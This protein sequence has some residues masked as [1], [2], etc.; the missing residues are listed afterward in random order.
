MYQ[1]RTL[2][3]NGSSLG[4]LS[5]K[6]DSGTGFSDVNLDRLLDRIF[7]GRISDRK[8]EQSFKSGNR[9][10]DCFRQDR[11]DTVLLKNLS[12]VLF[13]GGGR[14]GYQTDF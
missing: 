12:Q 9:T 5:I 6:T 4:D 8:V 11:K 14:L 1:K 13:P 10:C 7:H 3:L 2:G